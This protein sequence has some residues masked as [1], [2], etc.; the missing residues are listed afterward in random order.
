[1]ARNLTAQFPEGGGA[2]HVGPCCSSLPASP[3]FHIGSLRAN[4]PA[5]LAP[6][7]NLLLVSG[8]GKSGAPWQALGIGRQRT[9]QRNA[10]HAATL[11]ERVMGA[12]HSRRM[13]G[14]RTISQRL[15][16]H[17]ARGDHHRGL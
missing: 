7:A 5:P 16:C 8:L 17:P 11:T 13:A 9:G 10:L 12:L 2:Q 1:M 3:I 6:P 14:G 4:A 15:T